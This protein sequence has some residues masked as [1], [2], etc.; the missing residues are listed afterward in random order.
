VS[1][2]GNQE[3]IQQ[4]RMLASLQRMSIGL[5]TNIGQ[6]IERLQTNIN[7]ELKRLT[8]D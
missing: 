3:F 6:S 7:V 2:K 4:V 8:D 5:N 1:L